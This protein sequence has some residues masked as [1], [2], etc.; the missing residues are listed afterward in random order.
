MGAGPGP[1]GAVDRVPPNGE[2]DGPLGYDGD[3]GDDRLYG[4]ARRADHDSS[5]GRDRDVH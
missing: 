1:P 4:D 3:D 2:V 5:R